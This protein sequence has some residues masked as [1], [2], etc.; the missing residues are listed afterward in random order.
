[1]AAEYREIGAFEV[2]ENFAFEC[3]EIQVHDASPE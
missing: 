2:V 3:F 1:M